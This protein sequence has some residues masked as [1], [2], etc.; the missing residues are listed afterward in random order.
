MVVDSK[1][2][3]LEPRFSPTSGLPFTPSWY[4]RWEIG[5]PFTPTFV[6]SNRSNYSERKML[7]GFTDVARRAGK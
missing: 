2:E 5:S 4:F 3:G 1:A 7:I 6:N